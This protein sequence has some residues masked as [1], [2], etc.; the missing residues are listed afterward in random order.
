MRQKIKD[1]FREEEGKD[2]QYLK[3]REEL[4]AIRGDNAITRTEYEKALSMSVLEMRKYLKNRPMPK[5]D[6][7]LIFM[8]EFSKEKKVPKRGSI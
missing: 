7:H 4:I 6:S 8:A 2:E 3:V 5:D 1:Y